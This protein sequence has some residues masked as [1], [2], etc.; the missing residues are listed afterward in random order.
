MSLINFLILIKLLK[1]FVTVASRER[2][3]NVF[4]LVLIL[5]AATNLLNNLGVFTGYQNG[6]FYYYV[7]LAFELF[8]GLFVWLLK[9]DNPKFF[10]KLT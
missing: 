2:V 10:I 9:E 6:Y 7:S 3:I 1:E 4:I 8:I 5:Y